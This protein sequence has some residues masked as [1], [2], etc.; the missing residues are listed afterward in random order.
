MLVNINGERFDAL[1]LPIKKRWYDM[2]LS[3]EKRE[4][5]R[6]FNLYYLKRFQ[7]IGLISFDAVSA[8]GAERL[9]L[10]RNGYSGNS[11]CFVA[12]CTLTIG[13]GRPE[14]GAAEGE[15]YYILQIREIVAKG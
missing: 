1:P 8:T 7:N 3:G 5:Y 14:W 13:K 6:V 10:F 11:P 4:E 9:I 12:R 2:I 15:K